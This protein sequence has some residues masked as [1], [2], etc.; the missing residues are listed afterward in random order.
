MVLLSQC[1]M[2]KRAVSDDREFRDD[3]GV[4]K[5]MYKVDDSGRSAD[6]VCQKRY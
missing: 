4:R 1:E 3:D 5:K 2:A 6:D